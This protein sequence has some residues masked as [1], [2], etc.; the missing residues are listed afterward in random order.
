MV[1]AMVATVPSIAA[2]AMASDPFWAPPAGA[3]PTSGSYLYQESTPGSGLGT[4]GT[5]V[6]GDA[7]HVFTESG[8][9]AAVHVQVHGQELWQ[10]SFAMPDG[11]TAFHPGT[12]LGLSWREIAI[13]DRTHSCGSGSGDVQVLT[14][15]Y[16]EQDALNHLKLRYV[17]RCTSTSDPVRGELDLNGTVPPPAAT[18][19]T[20][21]IP[22]GLWSPA[23][24]QVPTSATYAFG[25]YGTDSPE[26]TL[27]TDVGV[28]QDPA[29]ADGALGQKIMFGSAGPSGV[30]VISG[31]LILPAR[32]ANPKVGYY[33]GLT[34][35]L[36]NPITGGLS[37]AYDHSSCNAVGW[38]AIDE[39]TMVGPNITHIAFR[40]ENVCTYG[41]GVHRGAVS[42][43]A[44][45]SI[46]VAGPSSGP[47]RGGTVVAILGSSLVGVTSITI[48]GQPAVVQHD[49]FGQLQAVTPALALG[50][51]DLVVHAAG[52]TATL[53]DGFTAVANP[54]LAP[55]VG[56]PS[57]GPN[58][59]TVTWTPPA[60]LGDGTVTGIEVVLAREASPDVID[61]SVV[62]APDATTATFTDLD[63]LT[64]YVSRVTYLSDVGRGVTSPTSTWVQ[65]TYDLGPF[66][67]LSSF[68]TRQYLD[69]AGRAPTATE[70]STAVDDIQ[71]GKVQSVA[72][73]A[74]MRNRPEWGG[75]RAPITR[76][77]LS[78]FQ[79][80]PDASGLTHWS[81]RLEDQE[82]HAQRGLGDV[83]SIVEEF[84]RK[85]GR[86]SDPAFVDLVYRNVLGRARM[87]RARPTGSR[88]WPRAPAAAP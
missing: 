23:P 69:F 30:P 10:G 40:Y 36:T 48:G 34:E 83:R 22:S 2:P 68:V 51:H 25:S 12:Y 79:R 52:G 73:L 81:D 5:E 55:T 11:A 24:G 18:S 26:T 33:G 46:S 8:S 86:L 27:L 58:A 61:R 16:S 6:L 67:V 75:V 62:V 9:A 17:Y 43:S 57:P 3:V 66:A 60:D 71:T 70:S 53:V 20:T 31:M 37:E 29:A 21:P 19:P 32:V 87:P 44:A 1:A 4:G 63:V 13:W 38:F 49:Q 47:R 50:P 54:P 65:T 78:Y 64:Y 59:A 39:L 42:W 82:E 72:W 80:L 7:N 76:L 41:G 84:K 85:Y 14:A 15:T 74:A 56:I 45:P 35:D 88:S 28:Q 77:Y